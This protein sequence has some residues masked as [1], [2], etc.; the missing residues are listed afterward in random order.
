LQL[1]STRVKFGTHISA[2]ALAFI[3]IRIQHHIDT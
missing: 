1:F 2:R 3:K